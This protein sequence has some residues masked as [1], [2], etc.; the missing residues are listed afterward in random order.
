MPNFAP[1]FSAMLGFAAGLVCVGV[2]ALSI[3]TAFRLVSGALTGI[4][5]EE[6]PA[7]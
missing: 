4:A 7:K 6:P 3:Y 5:I 1:V 2:V